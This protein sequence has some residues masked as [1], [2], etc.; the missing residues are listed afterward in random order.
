MKS[1]VEYLGNRSDS[2]EKDLYAT[3][4]DLQQ[5]FA[6]EMADLFRLSHLLTADAEEA[7]SCLILAIRDCFDKSAVSKKWLHLWARRMVVRTAIRRVLGT[8]NDIPCGTECDFHLQPSEFRTEAL[9]DSVAILGLPGFDRLVFV[10]CVL[11]RYS[12][13]DCALLLRRS[14]KDVQDARVRSTDRVISA[15]ARIHHETLTRSQ[16]S[17]CGAL[18]DK[19]GE[20]DGSCGTILD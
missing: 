11:E 10:I 15:G 20:P 7:E 16:A 14:P 8:E 5:F 3:P 13:L 6:I 9:W 17:N 12:I 19:S 4:E 18:C 1:T 2:R